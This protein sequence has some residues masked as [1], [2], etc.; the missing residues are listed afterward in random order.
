[1]P[2]AIPFYGSWNPELFEIERRCMDRDGQVIDHLDSVLPTGSVL[3]VGAGTG[4]TANKLKRDDRAIVAYEPSSGMAQPDVPVQWVRGI[5]QHLSLADDCVDAAYATWA[6][7]QPQW[8]DCQVGVAELHRV[9]RPGGLIVIVDNA[10]GRAFNALFDKD[11]TSDA[12]WWLER[13]FQRNLV[14]SS[15]RFDNLEE[16]YSLFEYYWSH[17]GRPAGSELTLTIEFDVAVY[18]KTVSRTAG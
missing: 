18:T 8:V 5:A 16:A 1:L 14:H 13:G 17:N 15:Y 11:L 7:F 3:D 9:V 6:Y 4:Y 2:D 12:G 10:G